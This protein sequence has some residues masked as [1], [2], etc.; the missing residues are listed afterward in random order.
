MIRNAIEPLL[1]MDLNGLAPDAEE[2][3]LL[4]HPAVGG[5]ILFSRN[6]QEPEQLRALVREVR[7]LRPDILIAVDQEGGRVQRFR[8]GFT[9]LPAMAALAALYGSDRLGLWAADLVGELMA[10]ELRAFDIDISFAPVLDLDHGNSS[11]IGDRSFHADPEMVVKLAGAFM[12]GMARAGMAATGKHFP[13]HGHVGADSHRELPDDP[14]TRAELE[15]DLL[16]FRVLAPRLEGIMPAHVRY[17]DVDAQPAGFSR[18]WLGEVLRG[19]CG[20][21]GVIFSDDLSMAG[22]AV[23]GSFEQRAQAALT[24]GCDMVLV[25]NDRAGAVAVLQWLETQSIEPR[26]PAAALRGRHRAPLDPERRQAAEV[27]AG[28]LRDS[29]G[30]E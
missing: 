27:V 9:R 21:R 24:A 10:D 15:A 2:R 16:P 13:G 5:L 30:K 14:R 18:Y 3:E 20:Y 19:E 4:A 17:S 11:V 1:M 23:A 29:S 8:E 25:C 7:T 6:Y 12:D 22:A 28:R 26:V